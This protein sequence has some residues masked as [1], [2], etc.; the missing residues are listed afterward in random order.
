MYLGSY[1]IDD[2]LT[3]YAQTQ[4]FDTGAATDADSAPAY[5]IYEDETATP[6]LT[7]TMATLDASNTDGYYSEQ[8][9]LSAAN[10]FEKGK[11]YSIRIAA[12]V[13]SVA[14]A[15]LRQFQ[16]EAEVDANTTS[17][18][19]GYR[20]SSTGVDDILRT[21]LVEAYAA[22]GAAPTLS[23]LLFLL[24]AVMSE[25]AISGTTITVRKLDG[26]TTA[27]TYTLDSSTAPTSRTRAT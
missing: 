5:R 11:C 16:M 14:G 9:T 13:N 12:T 10:G 1:K 3:F 23:Q 8:V 19:T 20:L 17:D 22:D 15:T 4:R 25:F 18:K 24:L 2:A 26:A 6:L 27:A 7:G 21:A